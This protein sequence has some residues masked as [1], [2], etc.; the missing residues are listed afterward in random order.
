MKNR[1]SLSILILGLLLQS[2][3]TSKFPLSI[4]ESCYELE[5]IKKGYKS[6]FKDGV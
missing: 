3:A 4:K 6:S 5:I 2:C 1:I